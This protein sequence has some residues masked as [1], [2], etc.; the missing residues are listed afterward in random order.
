[1]HPLDALTAA[2]IERAASI[3][4]RE[5]STEDV[6]FATI[7]LR[8]PDK[9]VVGTYRPGDPV[10]REVR[11]VVVEGPDALAEAVVSVTAD[12]MRSWRVV[13]GARPALLF[14]EI[15]DAMG[16]LHES[17]A[18]REAL[19][20]RGIT[21]LSTV[22][23][24]PWP[25]GSFGD[26]F[27][28]GTRL[29]R[30]VA[31]VRHDPTD[32][33][34]AHPIEGLV[35][36]VDLA[37]RRVVEILDHGVVPI[38]AE[39]ANYDIERAGPARTTLRPLEIVQPDGPSFTVEGNLLS[40]ENWRLRVSMDP[41][42]G[43]VLHQ[44]GW[45]DGERVRPILHRAALSEMVVP[46]GTTAPTHDWKNAF[47]AGEWGMGRFVN[48]LALGC[49]CLG[50]IVYLDAVMATERGGASTVAQAICL[51]EEDFGILWKHQDLHSGTTEV[52]RNRRFVISSIYTVGNYEYAFY[53][54]LYLDGTIELEVK[55]TG[56]MQ[57]MAVADDH[58]PLQSVMIAPELAAP[59]HQ[60]LFNV[61]LDM[62][63]DGP[64]NSVY[65]VDVEALP[66]GPDNPRSNAMTTVETLLETELG[67]QRL[68]D[69]TRSRTWRIVNPSVR[70][71]LGRPVAY[72][73]LPGAWP[74]LLAGEDASVRRRAGFATRHLWVTP[75]DEG[76]LRAA[77]P[78][79]NQ[80]T[81][82]G[83]PEWTAADRPVADTDVVLWCTFGVTHVPRPEDWPV[84]PVERT[85]FSLVPVGFFD[86]NPALDLP[87]S[88]GHCHT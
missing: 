46:Y 7:T 11:C 85:G 79:A 40:W 37:G 83:L 39:C 88:A 44:V 60:H 69:P 50:E 32:N 70:N 10:D 73:L 16:V 33:G 42:E 51:H 43:L 34:Y 31:Y 65:E 41:I 77:G 63:V 76:E 71:R 12:E 53:W 24:D 30:V 74:T 86:R 80:S 19:A 4:R 21:D 5:R 18:W 82:G 45:D 56:I 61:R 13:P 8:E 57:T 48:S 66:A 58:P 49:D 47:D 81:G 67:A 78:Y 1:M 68:V 64:G 28:E 54:Y 9:A 62:C 29:T 15:V 25:A 36:V 27:E 52:R 22:Q 6:L 2:E 84:M 35:A 38:P 26:A 23:V 17:E 75:F 87:P 59:L 72:K 14:T 55:L 3:V 20:R